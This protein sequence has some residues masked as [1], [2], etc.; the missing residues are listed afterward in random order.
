MRYASNVPIAYVRYQ[1]TAI[2]ATRVFQNPVVTQ[3]YRS[4]GYETV[5]A[6][7]STSRLI[8]EY[9]AGM[10]TDELTGVG[11][12]G[13]GSTVDVFHV[14]RP[15]YYLL[16][17]SLWNVNRRFTTY[18]E[19]QLADDW[20]LQLLQFSGTTEMLRPLSYY[21]P[22]VTNHDHTSLAPYD[23]PFSVAGDIEIF[24]PAATHLWTILHCSKDAKFQFKNE[25]WPAIGDP[26]PGGAGETGGGTVTAQFQFYRMGDQLEFVDAVRAL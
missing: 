7:Y 6:G 8:G 15:A 19:S 4:A 2:K 25:I 17:V 26:L 23:M 22:G 24:T 5:P 20:E 10:T 21:L 1:A 9:H 14:L 3:V 16:N 13:Y 12:Y 11:S 18:Y